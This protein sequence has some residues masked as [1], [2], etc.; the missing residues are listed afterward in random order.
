MPDGRHTAHGTANAVVCR[1]VELYLRLP[2]PESSVPAMVQTLSHV[3]VSAQIDRGCG[4]AGVA[5]DAEDQSVLIYV[6]D[7]IDQEHLDRRIRSDRFKVLLG[8]METCRA[9]PL[10]EVRFVSLVRG[11]DYVAALREG[12]EGGVPLPPGPA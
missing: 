10:L 8:L 12:P 11:L 9:A 4:H 6:E 1:V 2:T 7:W 3:M 5:R